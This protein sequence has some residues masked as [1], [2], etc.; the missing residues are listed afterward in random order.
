MKKNIFFSWKKLITLF[1]VRIIHVFLPPDCSLGYLLQNIIWQVY[2]S[3]SGSISKKFK[4][5]DHFHFFFKKWLTESELR[6]LIF[7][8]ISVKSIMHYT[9]PEGKTEQNRMVDMV[10]RNS[11]YSFRRNRSKFHFWYLFMHIL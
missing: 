8:T 1:F 5:L 6:R 2:S 9:F 10:S 3:M 7:Q 4:F 11:L